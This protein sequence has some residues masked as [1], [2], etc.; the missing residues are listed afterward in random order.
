MDFT[1]REFNPTDSEYEAIAKIGNAIL[2]HMP[3]TASELKFE[4]DNFNPEYTWK[5]FVIE[6]EGKIIGF[7]GYEDA[8]WSYQPG[9]FWVGLR[10]L[11]EY[12]GRGLGSQFYDH[13]LELLEPK[14]PS[15]LIAETREDFDKAIQ[16][17]EKRGFK[18]RMRFATSELDLEKF[19][20]TPF[21][22]LLDRVNDEGIAIKSL[23]ELKANDPDWM[24][25]LYQ[26]RWEILKDVPSPDPLTQ[27]TIEQ[28]DK[29][30]LNNPRIFEDSW[31]VAV[32]GDQYVGYSNLWKI[33]A[34][35]DKL[36]T[37][38]TG[39]VRSHRRKGVCTAMKIRAF[40]VAKQLGVKIIETEN[41]ENNPM[42]QINLRLGFEPRPAWLAFEKVIWDLEPHELNETG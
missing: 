25:K 16:F 6:F 2:P 42:Y 24:K 28:W 39:V 31:M 30:V 15:K 35:P 20:A 26:L 22:Q 5:R 19:C 38:L 34:R 9:K 14:D 40:D 7:G 4:D 36:D 23:P 37:G 32:D 18:K 29:E 3:T 10:V 8:Y 21:Q 27:D 33:L 41:E 13:L 12:Q 1:I 11:P 17:L